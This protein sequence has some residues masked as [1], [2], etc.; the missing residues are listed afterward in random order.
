MN[1]VGAC[2]GA[3]AGL[4]RVR[5]AVVTSVLAPLAGGASVVAAPALPAAAAT[6]GF[7]QQASAHGSGASIAV[8]TGANVTS[9]DRLVVEGST[10]SSAGATASSVNDSLGDAF[11]EVTHFTA[12]DGTEMSIWTAPVPSGGA[13]T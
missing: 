11:V 9:G 13:D 7:V 4:T 6:A 3:S 8:T 2:A 1:D 5:V 12:S 10:W